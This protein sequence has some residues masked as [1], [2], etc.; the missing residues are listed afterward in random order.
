VNIDWL[1]TTIN[2]GILLTPLMTMFV[3]AHLTNKRLL[4]SIKRQVDHHDMCLDELKKAIN[5]V[6]RRSRAQQKALG[7]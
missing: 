1:N 5:R 2:A 4:L 3:R 7:K 6:V